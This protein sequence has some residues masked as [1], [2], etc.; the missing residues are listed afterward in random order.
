M[1]TILILKIIFDLK[2]KDHDL[3]LDLKITFFGVILIVIWDHFFSCD[4]DL[5]DHFKDQDHLLLNLDSEI[6]PL[7]C[8]APKYY[9]YK[10]HLV[11][12]LFNIEV[13]QIRFNF[14]S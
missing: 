3:D 8:S 11:I 10:R 6:F 13:K 5:E 12:T 2:I 7:S 4:L 14:L 1:G 9:F